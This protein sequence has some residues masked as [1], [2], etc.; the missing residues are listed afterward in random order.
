MCNIVMNTCPFIHYIRDI[1]SLRHKLSN[2]AGFVV[3]IPFLTF[4]LRSSLYLNNCIYVYCTFNA[5]I[6]VVQMK[7]LNNVCLIVG[8]EIIV[9]LTTTPPLFLRRKIF[10]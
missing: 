8:E 3:K 6:Y 1:C 5:P 2:T 4:N 7:T 10:S 9:I